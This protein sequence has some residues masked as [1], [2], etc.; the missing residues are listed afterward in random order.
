LPQKEA[1]G[2]ESGLLHDVHRV[3]AMIIPFLANPKGL[4]DP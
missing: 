3:T 1:S 2:L 4:G